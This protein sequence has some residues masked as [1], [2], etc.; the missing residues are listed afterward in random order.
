MLTFKRLNFRNLGLD[1][2]SMSLLTVSRTVLVVDIGACVRLPKHARV[3]LHDTPCR[4][5]EYSKLLL[6]H[7]RSD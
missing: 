3:E 1:L 4:R 7:E 2:L 5:S 6:L